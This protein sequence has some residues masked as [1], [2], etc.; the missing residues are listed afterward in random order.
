MFA[1]RMKTA[2][3]TL[4][5]LYA[6]V[7]GSVALFYR[8]LLYP[9]PQSGV[10]PSLRGATLVTIDGGAPTS[11]GAPRPGPVFALY[12]KAPPGAPT[13]V[14][15]H[16]NGEELADEV[17]LARQL[18]DLGVGV[19]AVEYPGYGLA[20]NQTASEATLY[21][22]AERALGYLAE[23]NVGKDSIV[24]IGFS[25]G[26]GVAA[27]MAR[28]GHANRLV[29]IAPYT[30]IVDMVQRWVPIVPSSLIIGDRFDTLSKAKSLDLPV[31]VIHGDEDPVVPVEMGRRIARE[32]PN[33]RLDIVP[34]GHHADLFVRDTALA[35]R[36]VAFARGIPANP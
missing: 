32:L 12:A 25:L 10:T 18:M 35:E 33:A 26:T 6:S 16:G 13:L 34:G 14:H 28:R 9:A 7:V 30:S 4:S 27:E 24:L 2:A 17:L 5:L 8:T 1:R 23:Q 36:I 20:A 21:A 3:V 15:F 29:L 22:A 19:F 31:L 11:P